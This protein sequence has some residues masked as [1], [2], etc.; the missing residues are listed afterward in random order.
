MLFG[1]ISLLPSFLLNAQALD[2]AKHFSSTGNESPQCLEVD[3][4]GYVYSVGWFDGN[5][6]FDPGPGTFMLNAGSLPQTF[7]L[8]LDANGNFIWAKRFAGGNGSEGH[9]L[10]LDASSN[11][12]VTGN[13]SNT[14]DF[15]PGPGVFNL[16]SN[17]SSGDAY[18]CKLDNNGELV[19]AKQFSGPSSDDGRCVT[20]DGSGNVIVQ[21][22]F[23]GTV[24][25]NPGPGVFN[26]TAAGDRDIFVV[27]L[28]NAGVFQL[29]SK[30]GGTL[31]DGCF[32]VVVDIAGNIY[33][34]GYFL[35]TSDFDP[36]PAVFNLVAAGGADPFIC[37]LNAS[38]NLV[39]AKSLPG[40]YFDYGYLLRLDDAGNIFVAGWSDGQMDLDPGPG[41]TV[42]PY[43]GGAYD[44]FIA[45]YSNS[46]NLIWAR[47]FGG[48][49]SQE[50]IRGMTLDTSANIYLVGDFN[51]TVDFDPGPGVHNLIGNHSINDEFILKLD[52]AGNFR[53]VR[54]IGGSYNDF[55]Y[56]IALNKHQDIHLCGAFYDNADVDPESSVLIFTTPSGWV[57]MF[58]LKYNPCWNVMNTTLNITSCD[59]FSYNNINH[60]NSGT[61]KYTFTTQGGCDSIV[62][63][64]LTL[65]TSGEGSDTVTA[66]GSY[67]WINNYTYTSDTID[68]Y[69][70]A[71]G[72]SNGCDSTVTLHL[73]LNSAPTTIDEQT[74]CG[75]FT[76]ID[77]NT[78]TTS[79]NTPIYTF[80]TAEGCDSIISLD[81]E[82][83]TL[84]DSVTQ[85]GNTLTAYQA[86]AT[87]QW[88]D[89]FEH[90][91]MP[92]DTLQSFSPAIAGNY[93]VIVTL[94][95]CADT[96]ACIPMNPL[97][98]AFDFGS[99][100]V[101][102]FPNPAQDVLNVSFTV[103]HPGTFLVSINDMQGRTIS[104]NSFNINSGTSTVTLPMENL[105]EGIYFLEINDGN[106][107]RV[108]KV[109]VR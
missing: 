16:T 79:T 77:G 73:S 96:S 105:S 87:Y 97:G 57:D 89:C 44:S 75:A 85:S 61:F 37:K 40:P 4:A 17:N 10:K 25:F 66:C 35:G 86:G 20:L 6:D 39:W 62:T 109:I 45:K 55:I 56:S 30:L 1:F 68:M 71:G 50:I 7:I 53:W 42:F 3:T 83:V 15:D 22:I 8:K 28:N 46:G 80:T 72:S 51:D 95:G 103:K 31:D 38:G 69:T 21:G 48:P 102:Y 47:S 49:I 91:P 29:A 64:S 59:S 34:T 92:G 100:S 90:T 52:S 81:L 99:G 19:W 33:L 9:S 78:Y 36:G 26:L 13:F 24:D 106:V 104:T 12:Y 82:I 70:I 58:I 43:S 11:I 60:T 84:T 5:L 27:K 18:V 88:I 101:N 74:S 32:S 108:S 63:L 54:A 65:T 93:A 94:D 23:K 14:V 2:W 107:S 41:S 67:T 76:W 98:T